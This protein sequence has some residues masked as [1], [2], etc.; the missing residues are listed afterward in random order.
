MYTGSASTGNQLYKQRK[1]RQPGTQAATYTSSPSI[2]NQLCKQPKLRQAVIQTA[3]AQATIYRSSP[4]TGNQIYMQPEYWQPA[5]H[6]PRAH[7]DPFIR[8]FIF[9]LLSKHLPK[10]SDGLARRR[11]CGLTCGWAI[12][13]HFSSRPVLTFN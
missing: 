12:R 5:T 3:R 4:S 6:R 2:G 13:R 10:T 7:A 9:S 11:A 8:S 1:H